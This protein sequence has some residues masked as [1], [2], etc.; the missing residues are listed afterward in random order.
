MRRVLG[1]HHGQ[2]FSIRERRNGRASLYCANG[3]DR[4]NLDDAI[5]RVVAGWIPKPRDDDDPSVLAERRAAKRAAALRLWNG[6]E[7]SGHE[8]YLAARG[9]TA[10]ATSA[11]LR[12]RPDCPHPE[13]GKHPAIVAS[14]QSVD[15]TNVA[16]HRTYLTKDR[17]AKANVE[18]AK[19]SLGPIWGAATRLD[20][21]APD[22]VVA[23]GVETAASAGLLIGLPA[24]AALSAGNLGKGLVLPSE[25]G[26][27]V[28]AAD[29]DLEGER[30][31]VAA[32]LRWKAEGRTVRI[33]R[34]DGTGDFNDL[35]RHRENG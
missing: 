18:P 9:L 6:S 14:V 35:L 3:C 26:A 10:I 27:V 1:R 31:A 32:A 28:V 25:V 24:W 29:P 13:G 4:E 34:P 33:A 11:A 15:G 2:V 20:G 19:A 7:R 16:V 8:P 21:I 23:E 12:F 17:T 22:I 5:S 30:A